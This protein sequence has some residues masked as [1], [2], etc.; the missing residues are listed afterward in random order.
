[1]ESSSIT[2]GVLAQDSN[3]MGSLW[4]LRESIPEAAGKLGSVFK[5]DVSLPVEK[6]NELVE[7]MRKRLRDE[8]VY[9]NE[10][11][12]NGDKEVLSVVGYGHIGD[13]ECL[14]TDGFG[15]DGYTSTFFVFDSLLM[16]RID[17]LH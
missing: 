11:E 13:G 9:P 6:M 5:Y 8:G 2:D 15:G 10:G 16:F 3:Q 1:M 14:L 7:L 4:S 17:L 12:E